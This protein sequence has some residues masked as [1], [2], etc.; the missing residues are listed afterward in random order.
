MNRY[1]LH[2]ALTK[3]KAE[4]IEEGKRQAERDD[5][6]RTAGLGSHPMPRTGQPRLVAKFKRMDNHD[7][8]ELRATLYVGD[9]YYNAIQQVDREIIQQMISDKPHKRDE[10]INFWVQGAKNA[11]LKEFEKDILYV[12]PDPNDL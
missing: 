9:K 6:R 8:Y 1:E 4:G 11:I 3:A 7:A 10:Y 2:D 5:V 12:A